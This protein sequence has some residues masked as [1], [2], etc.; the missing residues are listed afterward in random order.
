MSSGSL[1]DRFNCDALELGDVSD[2]TSYTF[3]RTA[4]LMNSCRSRI[5]QTS[6]SH[7][8]GPLLAR[9]RKPSRG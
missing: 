8:R 3:N 9:R 4:V 7:A 2:I 1:I 5:S 6:Q